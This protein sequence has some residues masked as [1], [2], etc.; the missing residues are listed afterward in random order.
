MLLRVFTLRPACS[1]DAPLLQ[2]I[3]RASAQQFRAVG[4]AS[5]ADDEPQPLEELAEYAD[6]G[7][8]WVAIS[9]DN[10]LVGYVAVDEVDGNA[11][12]EQ[13]SVRPEHQGAGLGRALLDRVQ[14]WAMQSG[15]P[16]VTLTTYAD[17]AWNQP[18]YEHLGFR[19]LND[20]EIG[21]ELRA[22]RAAERARGLDVS[23]R[24]CMSLDLRH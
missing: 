19:V 3:E 23:P 17:V 13:V 12:V 6:S 21:P 14:Q 8:C 16:A 9:D 22:I 18:L 4:L 2:E 20:D 7:R 5:V 24:V 15:H 11:H 10:K 1:D